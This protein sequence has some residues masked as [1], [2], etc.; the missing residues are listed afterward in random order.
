MSV[1][2]SK[3]VLTGTTLLTALASPF[4]FGTT[5]AETSFDTDSYIPFKTDNPT[6]S[7]I[8][9]GAENPGYNFN[10]GVIE[11][12]DLSTVPASGDKFLVVDLE[13]FVTLGAPPPGGGPPPAVL[14]PTGNATIKVVGLDSSYSDVY[15]DPG[16]TASVWYDTFIGNPVADAEAT[17]A[18]AGLVYFD[19]TDVVDGWL[20]N[21]SANNGFGLVVTSGQ[22]VEL[23][24]SDD[25]LPSG[26][27]API[28]S[29]V[30]E[31]TSLALLAMGTA[32]MLRRRR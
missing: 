27:V 30:P 29:S 24:A 14:T 10:F 26:S 5:I 1:F 16:T 13:A 11:F 31:P 32:G 8:T 18:N 28:L 17:V 12:D 15:A 23:G 19:V 9:L 2:L 21:P 20:A 22:S 7:E 3:P 6:A 4:A 25:F